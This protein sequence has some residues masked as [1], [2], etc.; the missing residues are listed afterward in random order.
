MKS[1]MLL[2]YD[3]TARE[4]TASLLQSLGY[5]VACAATPQAALHASQSLRFD[6]VLTCTDSNA[7]DRRSF[8]GEL[9]RLA[10]GASIVYLLDSNA[11]G[12]GCADRASALL[13]K[14]VTLA[15]LRRVLEFGVDGLGQQQLWVPLQRERRRMPQRRL[16]TR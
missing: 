13:F 14:P 10:P 11:T 9:A 15:A 1:A 12:C 5:V 3:D 8:V 4:Q 6:A 7:D 2:E 16:R